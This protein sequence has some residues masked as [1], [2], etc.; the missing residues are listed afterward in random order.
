M[1]GPAARLNWPAPQGFATV[2]YAEQEC[3]VGKD[4]LRAP[5]PLRQFER[6]ADDMIF[7]ICIGHIGLRRT[8]A[9]AYRDA[10]TM[11]RFR[12]AGDERMPPVKIFALG[13]QRV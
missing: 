2:L 7:K 8:D 1:M 10:G 5:R 9:A 13:E 12:V 11:H 3:I 6:P 4:A